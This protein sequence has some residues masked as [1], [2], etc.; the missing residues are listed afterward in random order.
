MPELNDWSKMNLP[1]IGVDGR[2]MSSPVAPG[3]DPAYDAHGSADALLPKVH[4][5]L[6]G[7]GVDIQTF[8][9]SQDV[10]VRW[11]RSYDGVISD[12]RWASAPSLAGALL[13]ILDHEHQ[14]DI[15]DARAE[16]RD[17]RGAA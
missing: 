9:E 10:E 2:P 7:L 8:G 13:C 3:D 4:A 16:A 5:R 1:R 11:R 6:G 14:A 15:D 17:E 12:E